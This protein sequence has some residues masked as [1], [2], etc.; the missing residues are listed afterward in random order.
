M[1]RSFYFF[2]LF[3][4]H[5]SSLFLFV[6]SFFLLNENENICICALICKYKNNNYRLTTNSMITASSIL[7][8]LAQLNTTTITR[9]NNLE[10]EAPLLLLCSIHI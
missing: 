4:L 9:N 1:F 7:S 3:L 5:F 6:F 8:L 10:L 2:L